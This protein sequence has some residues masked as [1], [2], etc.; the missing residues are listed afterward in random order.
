MVRVRIKNKCG[1]VPT[2]RYVPEKG[3][4][5]CF[6]CMDDVGGACWSHVA[7]LRVSDLSWDVVAV[8]VG[9]LEEHVQAT[10]VLGQRV[11]GDPERY[12]YING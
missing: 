2:R 7:F 8:D 10:L 5:G 11:S 9:V 3:L 6:A 12:N 4:T 1:G